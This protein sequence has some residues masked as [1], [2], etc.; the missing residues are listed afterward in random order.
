M[1]LVTSAGDGGHIGGRTIDPD[2]LLAALDD[3]QRPATS[4]G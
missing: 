3:L 2:A 4:R 1:A